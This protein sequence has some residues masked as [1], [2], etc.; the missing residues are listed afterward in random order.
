MKK[1]LEFTRGPQESAK[2]AQR[3]RNEKF[4]RLRE[5][6]NG[7]FVFCEAHTLS[8]ASRNISAK[9]AA[10]RAGPFRVVDQVGN[11]D[12]LLSVLASGR[13]IGVAHADQ[14]AFY[15]GPWESRSPIFLC[16]KGGWIVRRG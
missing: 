15:Y 12:F 9:L 7:D 1:A 2:R 10:R 6:E 8:N 14:L 16:L 5:V 3:M 4:R 11:N 13:P